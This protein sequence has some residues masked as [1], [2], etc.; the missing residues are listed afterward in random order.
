MRGG[1]DPESRR[2]RAPGW[3]WEV[4]APSSS[5]SLACLPPPAPSS[6]PS[7][8]LPAL[9]G[10]GLPAGARRDGTG[11]GRA[12]RGRR[13]RAEGCG[14]AAGWRA[15]GRGGGRR[16]EAADPGPRLRGRSE[17]EGRGGG[18]RAGSAWHL[19]AA[20]PCA[21]LGAGLRRPGSVMCYF[22]VLARSS[23]GI[24]SPIPPPPLQYLVGSW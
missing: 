5:P 18:P 17:G 20:G 14:P 11:D 16:A 8:P 3:L 10:R 15:L 1:G 7:P 23:R 19:E 2:V 22:C 4:R 21:Q 24:R 12:P 13:G 6:L 9:P